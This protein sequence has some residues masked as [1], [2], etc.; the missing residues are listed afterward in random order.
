MKYSVE[1][2]EEYAILTLEEDNLNSVKAPELK[3]EFYMLKNAGV[4]NLILS[5]EKV[6]YVDSSGLSAILTGNR[7]WAEDEQGFILTGID[8]PSVRT[9]I[10]ISRLDSVL[11]IAPN[12]AEAEKMMML[13]A[14][15]DELNSDEPTEDDTNEE[16]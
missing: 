10:T 15:S 8:H 1:K 7:I 4:A 6:K 3:S 14:F 16:D 2:K 12:L 11:T 13:Q 9:L 5:L